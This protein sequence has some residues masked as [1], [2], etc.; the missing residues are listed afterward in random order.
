V[1][2]RLQICRSNSKLA[3]LVAFCYLCLSIVLPMQHTDLFV[4]P[5]A[6]KR[7]STTYGQHAHAR[8][9]LAQQ[10]RTSLSRQDHC[11]ACEWQADQVSTAL[12]A[13]TLVLTPPQ[14]IRAITTF[15][16]YLRLLTF[17]ASSRAPPLA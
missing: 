9:H 5:I 1:L 13:F 2:F 16:R 8:R 14:P 17:P 3:A 10:P 15:P 7:I 4:R 12:P 11:L 6:A